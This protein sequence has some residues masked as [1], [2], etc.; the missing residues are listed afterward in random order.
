MRDWLHF[1][2]HTLKMERRGVYDE[3]LAA[4]R[5]NSWLNS[6]PL[7]PSKQV[8]EIRY[9]QPTTVNDSSLTKENADSAANYGYFHKKKFSGMRFLSGFIAVWIRMIRMLRVT[10]SSGTDEN[11]TWKMFSGFRQTTHQ[12]F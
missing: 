9:E 8:F 6:S 1:P 7:K 4:R 2:P 12:D 10:F 11:C 3:V 5:G